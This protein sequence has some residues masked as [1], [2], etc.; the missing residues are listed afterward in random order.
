VRSTKAML[1]EVAHAAGFRELDTYSAPSLI[2][3]LRKSA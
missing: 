1:D 2:A 3:G